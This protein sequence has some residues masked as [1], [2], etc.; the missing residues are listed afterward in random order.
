MF[1]KENP[2]RKKKKFC[3]ATITVIYLVETKYPEHDNVE[4]RLVTK[5]LLI[6]D[7]IIKICWVEGKL[8]SFNKI[9]LF[10]AGTFVKNSHCHK[11][12]I[13]IR[14][15]TQPAGIDLPQLPHH[16]TTLSETFFQSS[17]NRHVHFL[18]VPLDE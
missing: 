3:C 18:V 16:S 4:K 15:N 17:K 8:F 12:Q 1:V 11:S 14:G 7:I 13:K 5:K 10:L 9:G 6:K 2:D